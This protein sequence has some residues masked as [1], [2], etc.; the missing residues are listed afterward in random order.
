MSDRWE[1][2]IHVWP[3]STGNGQCADQKAVGGGVRKV[4]VIA[5]RID[6]ALKLVNL[7]RDG[8]ETNPMVWQAVVY[9]IVRKQ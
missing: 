9:G 7:Y 2:E 8:I 5:H 1:A 6:D 4:E 3:H